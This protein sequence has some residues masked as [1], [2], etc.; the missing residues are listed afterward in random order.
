L[1]AEFALSVLTHEDIDGAITAYHA[2]FSSP[3]ERFWWS[4]DLDAMRAFHRSNMERNLVKHNR[5]YFKIKHLASGRV[6]AWASW[7]LPPGFKRLGGC[8]ATADEVE[9]IAGAGNEVPD[10]DNQ[11]AGRVELTAEQKA[12]KAMEQLLLPEGVSRK[13][14]EAVAVQEEESHEKH[15]LQEMICK[16][17]PYLT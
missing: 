8:P 13:A 5:P 14:L 9:G 12:K 10:R 11:P 7:G 6:A 17:F 1:S 2:A 15:G 4:P 16:F 3:A